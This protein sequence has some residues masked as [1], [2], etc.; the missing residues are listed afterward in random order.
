MTSYSDRV[1]G[2]ITEIERFSNMSDDEFQSLLNSMKTIIRHN[3]KR[4][5]EKINEITPNNFLLENLAKS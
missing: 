2:I 5:L 3:Y 4:F 1:T